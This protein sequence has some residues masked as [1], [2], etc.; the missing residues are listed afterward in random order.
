MP[1]KLTK[2]GGRCPLCKAPSVT[3]F[4]PFCSRGCRDRDLLGWL[5]ENYRIAGRST[6]EDELQK[7]SDYGLD[8]T[9]E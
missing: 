2:K 1:D 8:S 7:S 3:E 6:E 5:G 4:A 9:G